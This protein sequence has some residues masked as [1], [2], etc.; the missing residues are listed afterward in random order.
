MPP[1][2]TSTHT[3][4]QKPCPDTQSRLRVPHFRRFSTRS[5]GEQPAGTARREFFALG[6]AVNKSWLTIRQAAGP[7]SQGKIPSQT[8][9]HF[10]FLLCRTLGN[11]SSKVEVICKGDKVPELFARHGRVVWLAWERDDVYS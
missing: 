4:P 3:H 10:F 2:S 5:R 11:K 8:C 6:F 1:T 9:L 7:R